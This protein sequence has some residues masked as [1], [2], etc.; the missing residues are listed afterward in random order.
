MLPWARRSLRARRHRQTALISHYW[1]VITGMSWLD[2]G[3]GEGSLQSG[4]N[5]SSLPVCEKYKR[6]HRARALL[7]SRIGSQAAFV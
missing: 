4:P 6:Q 7:Q 2:W 1:Y 3:L 5:G